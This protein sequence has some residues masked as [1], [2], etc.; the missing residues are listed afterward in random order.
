MERETIKSIN[1]CIIMIDRLF[2]LE[3]KTITNMNQVS[4]VSFLEN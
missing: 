4:F 2:K 1:A 3:E